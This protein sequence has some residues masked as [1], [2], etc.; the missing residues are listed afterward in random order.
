MVLIC[1]QYVDF[2]ADLLRMQSLSDS[3]PW[4]KDLIAAEADL[5]YSIPVPNLCQLYFSAI[6]SQKLKLSTTQ[7]TCWSVLNSKAVEISDA[8]SRKIGVYLQLRLNSDNAEKSLQ[9][10]SFFIDKLSSR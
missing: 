9:V 6:H 5:L 7:F 8:D 3:V 4:L 10:L 1:F 2:M